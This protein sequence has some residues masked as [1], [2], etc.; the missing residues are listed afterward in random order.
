MNN[1]VIAENGKVKTKI[2]VLR[3][4][5][6]KKVHVDFRNDNIDSLRSQVYY[7]QMLYAESLESGNY[8]IKKCTE[9]RQY[10]ESIGHITP[11]R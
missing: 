6:A 10:L 1:L 4:P 2:R 5:N 7:W 3:R 8:W 11:V 9:F